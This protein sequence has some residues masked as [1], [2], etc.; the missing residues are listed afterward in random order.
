MIRILIA[1]LLLTATPAFA[2]MGA[3]PPLPN[4]AAP[5]KTIVTKLFSGT[6]TALGQDI[7][8]PAT[9]GEVT[10]LS[11]DIPPGA[12]LPVHMHKHPRYAYVLAGRLKVSTADGSQSFEYGPGDF[13]VEML[14]TWHF[15]ETVGADAVKLLVIDQAP[16]GETNTLLQ[17]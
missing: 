5:A 6:K 9:G 11:Y 4:A 8:L 14:D 16:A 15:G 7:A 3:P 10:V 2:D 13:I 1:A 12:K 17:Q